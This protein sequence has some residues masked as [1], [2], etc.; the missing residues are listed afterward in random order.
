M[1]PHSP[2]VS[3][4]R[5]RLRA[6]LVLATVALVASCD[7]SS[8]PRTGKLSLSVGGL[9][10]S[11]AAKVTLKGPNGFTRA[12]TG[13]EVVASLKP[14]NYSIIAESVRDGLTRYSP[15]ADSQAVTITKSD[16]PVEAS[17]AYAISSA[18]LTVTLTGSPTGAPAA[19]R[20][21]GPQSFSQTIAQ[22]TTFEGIEPGVYFI[23]APEITADQ[24]RFS[25]NR[26]SQ[27]VQ[28]SAG[29]NATN[30]PISYAQITGNLTFV[31]TGLP[32]GVAGDISVTGPAQSYVVGASAD[33]IG[34]RAGQY[35][36]NVKP[37]QSGA[38]SY[39]PNFSAQTVTL[40]AGATAVVTVNYA[41]SDGPLNLTIDG[42]TL[43]QVVQTYSGTVPLIAGRDAFIRVFAR[44]NQQNTSTAQ[45]RVRFYVGEALLHT[46]NLTNS[47]TVPL[48]ADQSALTSS[49][50]GIVLGQFIQP[51][52]KI[53]A[54]VDP[55]NTVVEASETDNAFPANGTPAA[56]TVKD[57]PPL[58]ITFVPVI[59]RFDKALIGNVTDAN[60]DQFLIDARRLLPLRDI[61][62]QVHAPYTTADSIE[63]TSNDGNQEW[64]RIL[65][66]LNAL[67]I[68]E[69][70]SRNYFGV[71][72]VSYNAGVAG[73]GYVPGRAA[74]GWDYLPSG[75]NVAAHELGHNF[76]R[77]H[78]PCGGVGGPD[79]NYPYAGGT[80]GVYGYDFTSGTVRLPASADL[81]GYCNS[82]W[83]SDYNFVG[84]MDWREINPAP[85]VSSASLGLVQDASPRPSLL[86][87][88]RVERGELVL[89]PAFSL[90]TRPSVPREPGPYRVE[91]IARNGRTLFSYSFAGERPADAED[92]TARHFA[93]AIPMDEATQGELASIRLTGGGARSATMQAGV[94][95]GGVAAAVN[96]VDATIGASGSVNVRWGAG[97]ARM[98]LIRDRAT[99]QVLSFARGGS[100]SVRARSG[101]IEVTVSDGVRSAS[102]V[103]SARN[104]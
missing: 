29:L 28:L 46:M 42:V 72:K 74:V 58:R 96:A 45:V 79:P 14:G 59:Q 103:V 78:A 93:F 39:V 88:G 4:A 44:A 21:T 6:A 100:A 61:D 99:G 85:D 32:S 71:V 53:L 47:A 83:I 62:A 98:A 75:R 35:T 13:T 23:V 65:N 52:L 90:V 82:P 95:P 12:L 7:N 49:W 81:M 18:T 54:E 50:N 15:L 25:A 77:F 63:I 2:S 40:Q 22:T 17:I 24:Q 34:V 86:V 36:V 38:T 37:V 102:R 67:R 94:A 97:A 27:Q 31:V 30:V 57:V 60:K 56:I 68:A 19:V 84:A 10:S 64:L 55:A 70:S 11:T 92:A 16:V 5:A 51:G 43:T 8:G 41:S 89:E 87:W 73:Y 66:E 104:R 3:A 80:I 91:G 101:D 9:P 48:T 33:L 20:I 69:S 1:T 26:P 76:S